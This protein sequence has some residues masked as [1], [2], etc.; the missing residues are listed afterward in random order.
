MSETDY[1]GNLIDLKHFPLRYHGTGNKANSEIQ[2][3]LAKIVKIAKER[4]KPIVIEDL[5]FIKTKSKRTNSYG[6]K[7]KQYNKM[8][9]AFDYS[10]YKE[11]LANV[12]YRNKIGLIYVN[13]AY[14]SIIGESKYSKRMKLNRHQAASYVIARKGQGYIDKLIK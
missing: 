14:T 9:H 2:Q 6:K 7:G 13:A 8:I 10:R 5:D 1:Y 12:C 3:V 4:Q 11:R